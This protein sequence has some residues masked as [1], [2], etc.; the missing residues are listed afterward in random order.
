MAPAAR[1]A[2]PA[3]QTAKAIK[4]QPKQR[5]TSPAACVPPAASAV[6]SADLRYWSSIVPPAS[7]SIKAS[8]TTLSPHSS[9]HLFFSIS[10][11]RSQR[12]A[13]SASGANPS[14]SW[15]PF[16]SISHHPL[17]SNIFPLTFWGV[18]NSRNASFARSSGY[19]L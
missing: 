11:N 19:F 12:V 17:I 3:R 16:S 5:S 7:G 9:S 14:L 4:S 8:S 6:T 2:A 15:A 10:Q 1:M 13:G 18:L